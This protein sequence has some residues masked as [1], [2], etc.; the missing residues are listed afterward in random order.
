MH[1]CLC[2]IV[3]VKQ[4]FYTRIS[5]KSTREQNLATNFLQMLLYVYLF[6]K[7][8]FFCALVFLVLVGVQE[9]DS[10]SARNFHRAIWL[11]R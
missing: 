7:M 3:C 6:P 8:F 11:S 9:A 4:N 2:Q 1:L 10:G 5:A